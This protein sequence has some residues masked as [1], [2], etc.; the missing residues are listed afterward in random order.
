VAVASKPL[1]PWHWALGTGCG[2][3]TFRG[4]RWARPLRMSGVTCE[5][6]LPRF[7]ASFPRPL[8]GGQPDTTVRATRQDRLWNGEC[9]RERHQTGCHERARQVKVKVADVACPRPP[10]YIV[11]W[12]KASPSMLGVIGTARASAASVRD[13]PEHRLREDC[14]R[15][16]PGQRDG[17]GSLQ[18]ALNG[19]S[20]SDPR[21]S[22]I[23][24]K[25]PQSVRAFAFR[26]TAETGQTDGAPCTIPVVSEWA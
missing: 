9:A 5:Q 21:T 1:G 18:A 11:A 19:W 13:P 4:A 26:F 14:V 23:Q 24:R 6:V 3:G 10:S 12:R 15:T 8:A 7:T 25:P 17:G 16:M 22:T 20:D 2:E